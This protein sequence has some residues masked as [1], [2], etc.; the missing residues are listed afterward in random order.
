M[1]Q[2]DHARFC[3]ICSDIV[4]PDSHDCGCCTGYCY[5]C[6]EFLDMVDCHTMAQASARILA[7]EGTMQQAIAD[8][9]IKP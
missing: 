1:N 9:L 5:R 3:P 2:D 8:G 4:T 6:D 7:E